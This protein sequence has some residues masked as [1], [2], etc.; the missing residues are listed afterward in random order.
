MMGRK[1]NTEERR[2]EIVAALRHEMATV[3][4]ERASTR[5]IAERA[6]LA[7]GLV[8]YHFSSKQEILHALVD[9]LIADADQR[10]QTAAALLTD[11]RALLTAYIQARVGL[12]AES[13]AQQVRAWVSLIGEAMGQ[14]GVR[15]RV[16]KWLG[17]D[18]KRLTGLFTD[19]GAKQ[20]GQHAALLLAAILGSFSLHALRVSG[21]PVGYAEPELLVWVAGV[22]PT[23][24]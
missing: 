2:R 23:A 10:W 19:A 12:G 21:V 4:Y 20:P 18:Q 13:D 14:P 8:H 15:G 3:G 5:S 6:G 22:L 24:E 11:P 9:E 7:P 16:A 17:K 1:S